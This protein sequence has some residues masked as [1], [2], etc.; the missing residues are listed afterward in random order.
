M[1]VAVLI[2][3]ILRKHTAGRDQVS[4]QGSNIREVLLSLEGQF[5]GFTQNLYAEDGDLKPFINI[6]VNEEDIRFLQDLD[7]PVQNNDTVT[8]LPAIAGG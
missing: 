6:Y 3:T 7:T 4:A 8:I 1:A 2:P 5:Q